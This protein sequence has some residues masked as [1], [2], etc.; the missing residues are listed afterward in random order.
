MRILGPTSQIV[1]H[2]GEGA[3]VDHLDGRSKPAGTRITTMRT[4][5]FLFFVALCLASS[6]WGDAGRPQPKWGL[7]LFG[8]VT[9]SVL[10]SA[11]IRHLGGVALWR[12][13]EVPRLRYGAPTGSLVWEAYAYRSHSNGAYYWHRDTSKNYG[14]EAFARYRF[15]KRGGIGFYY[16]VGIGLQY[17]NHS[18]YDLPSRLNATPTIDFGATIGRRTGEILVGI[19]IQHT[20]NARTKTRNPSQNAALFTVGYGW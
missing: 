9:L 3:F 8:G 4:R 12:E 6:A 16:D 18:I 19:R 5:L 10:G 17:E 13:L 11:D 7:T 15:A 2:V 20:S 1:V 14:I